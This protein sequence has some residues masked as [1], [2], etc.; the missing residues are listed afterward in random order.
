MDLKHRLDRDASTR[1]AFAFQ[2]R[3]ERGAV[4]LTCAF[5]G[6]ASLAAYLASNGG[7]LSASQAIVA[8]AILLGAML[9][10]YACTRGWLA[11]RSRW[12]PPP[13]VTGLEP[14]TR[15]LALTL[16]SALET[17]SAGQRE[18]RWP[19]FSGELR[20]GDWLLL[21]V[22]DREC[23]AIPRA[24]LREPTMRMTRT[25]KS[26]LARSRWRS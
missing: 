26:L 16:E 18:F 22:S 3:G 1:L 20:S 17:T 15:N 11:L 6:I 24:A 25:L 2:R 8:G 12:L 23:L 9:L 13:P 21:R 5:V 7:N 19:A 4:I 10:T 14:G